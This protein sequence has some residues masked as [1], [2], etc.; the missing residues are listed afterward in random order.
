M[1]N[2]AICDHNHIATRRIDLLEMLMIASTY[3]VGFVRELKE[4]QEG[5]ASRFDG[6]VLLETARRLTRRVVR[7]VGRPFK[8]GQP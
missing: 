4:R 1:A 8:L 2:E 3:Y 6:A 5:F 7:L